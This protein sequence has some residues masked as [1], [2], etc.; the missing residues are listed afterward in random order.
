MARL[1]NE[2]HTQPL[3]YKWIIFELKKVIIKL[4]KFIDKFIYFF[5]VI[6]SLNFPKHKYL[7]KF[8]F[9]FIHKP[10][11]QLSIIYCTVIFRAVKTCR[12]FTQSR[13][14]TTRKFLFFRNKMAIIL[15]IYRKS[16]AWIWTYC[17]ACFAGIS[18]IFSIFTI[19]TLHFIITSFI[20]SFFENTLSNSNPICQNPISSIFIWGYGI[21]STSIFSLT[22]SSRT[23][24]FRKNQQV[25]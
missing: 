13:T 1:F 23:E 3:L 20:L 16:R 6:K 2:K 19:F 14:I 18:Y 15:N 17:R 22:G 8:F 4:F 24:F 11:A 5:T 9:P 25:S 7:F 12:I 10:S 21:P